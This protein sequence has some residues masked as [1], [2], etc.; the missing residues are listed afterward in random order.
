MRTRKETGVHSGATRR[1]V[2]KDTA[3][4]PE[5]QSE[6]ESSRADGSGYHAAIAGQE[7]PEWLNDLRKARDWP[8]SLASLANARR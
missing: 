5:S 4:S 7:E 8:C 2:Y 1:G 6:R 3:Y